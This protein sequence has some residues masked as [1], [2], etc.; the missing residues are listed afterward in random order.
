MQKNEAILLDKVAQESKIP[1]AKE[2]S[3]GKKEPSF[4]QMKS[5]DTPTDAQTSGCVPAQANMQYKYRCCPTTLSEASRWHNKAT[6]NKRR[7]NN[8]LLTQLY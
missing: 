6:M 8:W 3:S 5:V 2:N 4:A 1:R 7:G